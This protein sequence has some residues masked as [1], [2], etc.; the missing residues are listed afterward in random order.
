M[1][2]IEGAIDVVYVLDTGVF[3]FVLYC[4]VVAFPNLYNVPTGQVLDPLFR[5]RNQ[6]LLRDRKQTIT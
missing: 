4:C 1:L 5:L 6:N 2:F 3:S